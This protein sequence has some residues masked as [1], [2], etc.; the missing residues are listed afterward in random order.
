MHMLSIETSGRSGSIALLEGEGDGTRLV[1]ETLLAGDQRTAQVLAPAIQALLAT[2]E[3]SAASIELVAVVVGPGSFTGLRIGVTT[4]KTLAYALGAAVVGVNT[5][6]VLA[7][8]APA[9]NRPLWAVLDAQRQELFAATFAGSAPRQTNTPDRTQIVPATE[10]WLAESAP[11]ESVT[12][13]RAMPLEG[14][15]AS[16]RCR[17][18]RRT[19]AANSQRGRPHRLGRLPGGSPG[20]H[21]DAR[22][23]VLS[24]QCGGGEIQ[25]K[26]SGRQGDKETLTLNSSPCPHVPLSPC[27]LDWNASRAAAM[28][29]ST[30]ASEWAAETNS[31]SY[32]LHGK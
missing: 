23:A 24:S 15:T 1:G 32:W 28:V 31:A 16:E 30:S 11:G 2:A 22:A 12:G 14:E 4:A 19:L 13:P 6:D 5:L 20:R 27:H 8:Q 18:C 17:C 3:W 29:A 7:A 26:G 9:D 25:V 10:A 21:L